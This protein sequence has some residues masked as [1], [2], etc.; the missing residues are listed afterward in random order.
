M[1]SQP[2][3]PQ[4]FTYYVLS[5]GNLMGFHERPEDLFD[6]DS[7]Q[8]FRRVSWF[9][10]SVLH[11][12]YGKRIDEVVRM[13]PEVNDPYINDHYKVRAEVTIGWLRSLNVIAGLLQS[14]MRIRN[15]EFQRQDSVFNM[16]SDDDR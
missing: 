3:E 2:T 10:E 15:P 6:E 12:G 1:S 7:D 9:E 4:P 16:P 5:D 13:F 8:V 14:E 11:P